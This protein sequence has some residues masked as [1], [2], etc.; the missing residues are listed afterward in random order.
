MNASSQPNS[1]VVGPEATAPVLRTVATNSATP[2]VGTSAGPT[3][4]S[5]TD[6][7][8]GGSAD[9][10]TLFV[11]TTGEGMVTAGGGASVGGAIGGGVIEGDA[12]GGGASTGGAAAKGAAAKGAAASGAAAS[13]A[14][15]SGA[16]ASGCVGG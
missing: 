9:V 16:A 1:S 5:S 3:M 8:V 2:P 11:A 10:G 14:A 6:G 12:I 15:A 4:P 7:A 13:G